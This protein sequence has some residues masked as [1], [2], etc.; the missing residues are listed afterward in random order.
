MDLLILKNRPVASKDV[1][2]VWGLKQQA[3]LP[4]DSEEMGR[5]NDQKSVDIS[6][7]SRILHQAVIRNIR[8]RKVCDFR[9]IIT[10]LVGGFKHFL[11]LP[12]FVEMIQFD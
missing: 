3:D 1:F 4:W 2:I 5:G 8:R 7:I 12:L 10:S 9:E 11:F 6:R